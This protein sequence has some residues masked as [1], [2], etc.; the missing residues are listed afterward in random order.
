VDATPAR[1]D[2]ERGDVVAAPLDHALA[3]DRTGIEREQ[4]LRH[5]RARPEPPVVGLHQFDDVGGLTVDGKLTRPLERW[6]TRLALD[7]RRPV[8]LVRRGRLSRAQPI[9]RIRCETR[10]DRSP[11]ASPSVRRGAAQGIDVGEPAVAQRV[12]S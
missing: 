10:V 6:S 7:E 5:V 4:E 12:R 9:D 1:L 3:H 2:V 8:P 11:P